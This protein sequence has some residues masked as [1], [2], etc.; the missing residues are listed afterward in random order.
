MP[1]QDSFFVEIV[2]GISFVYDVCII[3]LILSFLFQNTDTGFDPSL[4]VSV[5]AKYCVPVL[6]KEEIELCAPVAIDYII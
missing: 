4:N 6:S 2:L 5:A 3:C 1:A